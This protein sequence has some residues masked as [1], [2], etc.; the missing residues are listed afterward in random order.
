[1]QFLPLPRVHPQRQ[2]TAVRPHQEHEPVA[3]VAAPVDVMA[4]RPT[5][6]QL[7]LLPALS[8]PQHLQHGGT[9]V[10]ETLQEHPD[11]AVATVQEK[12]GLLFPVDGDPEGKGLQQPSAVDGDRGAPQAGLEAGQLELRRSRYV[13]AEKLLLEAIKLDPK[14]VQARRELVYI[15]GMQLRRPEINANFRE[16]ARI[17]TLTYSEVFLWCLSRGVSWEVNEVI[18]T[19][20]KCL[21]ADPNDS[22]ARLGIAEGLRE[23][24]RFDEADSIL[25][26]L[27]DSDPRARAT[28]VRLALDRGDDQAAETLL[29]AGPSDDVD[30]T[31]LR[32]RFALAR[33]DGPEAVR[34]FRIAHEEAP[35]LREAVI[36]LGQSLQSIGDSAAAAPLLEEARKHERL[37]TL[38]VKA[39]ALKNRDDPALMR[40]LGEACAALGRFTEARTWYNLA[41]TRDPFDIQAQD[42]IQRVKELEARAQSPGPK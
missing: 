16:L 36:G 10:G 37:G 17:S 8:R 29:A 32:G 2:G 35:S 21:E 6:A 28:R 40:D 18:A 7:H 15:Y 38:I 34:Q 25:A 19:L 3:P 27:P 12:F 39:S 20:K 22:W 4:L 1:V 11:G 42:G 13:A 9:I 30:L 26:P 5:R 31:L 14:S 23:L 24:R 41:I 33:G